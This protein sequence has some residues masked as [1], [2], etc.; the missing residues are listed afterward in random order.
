MKQNWLI[1]LVGFSLALNA[2]TLGA[3]A[4]FRYQDRPPPPARLEAPPLYPEMARRLNL[5]P[6][7]EE[8][9]RRLSEEQRRRLRDSRREL[10]AKRREL[11]A[12]MQ[13]EPLPEWPAVQAKLREISG[14]QTRLAEEMVQQFWELQRHLE[15][16]QRAALAAFL[17]QRL[18]QP[19]PGR[20]RGPRGR[21]QGQFPGPECPPGPPPRP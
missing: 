13:S 17:E 1:Y 7:Q 8:L 5:T 16:G 15:P 21:G 19:V 4:Y 20:M 3:L 18:L 9:F 11:L 14:L 12:L 10:L 6:V 2:G